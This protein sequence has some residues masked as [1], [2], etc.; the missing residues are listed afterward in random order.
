M[1]SRERLRAV[2]GRRQADRTGFWLGSPHPDSWPLYFQ[3]FSLST[4]EEVR[5]LLGDDYRHIC[6]QWDCYKHPAGKPMLDNPRAAPGLSAAGGRHGRVP[7][8]GPDPGSV[9]RSPRASRW[10]S[11]RRG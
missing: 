3:A 8:S 4:Q 9:T 1:T 7:R 2:F 11:R 6:R 10:G 5:R